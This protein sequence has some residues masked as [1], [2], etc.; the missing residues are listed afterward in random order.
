VL[1][2]AGVIITLILLSIPHMTTSSTKNFSYLKLVSEVDSGDVHTASVHP[3]GA[4]SGV[5]KGGHNYTTQIL[6]A[7]AVDPER[8]SSTLGAAAQL[9]DGRVSA[10]I[11]M[12]EASMV[13][14][15]GPER[16]ARRIFASII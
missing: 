9:L 15:S 1:L 6:T 7:I 16:R 12:T 11:S 10:A 5:L 13:T 4:I 8:D 14:H 2:P 3:R